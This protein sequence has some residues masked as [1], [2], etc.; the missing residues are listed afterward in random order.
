MNTI[1]YRLTD[2]AVTNIKASVPLMS[3]LM[4]RFDRRQRTIEKMLDAKDIRFTEPD[5]VDIIIEVTGLYKEQVIE[6]ATEPV[7]K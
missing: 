3:K 7:E 4:E 5:V 1:E 2:L 6:K